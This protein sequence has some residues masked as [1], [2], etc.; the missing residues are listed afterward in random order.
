MMKITSLLIMLLTSFWSFSQNPI[1]DESYIDESFFDFKVRL[2]FAI[3]KKDK[4]LLKKLMYDKILEC[5]D[6]FDCAGY[7]GCDKN[8]FI[9]IYFKDSLSP[10]WKTLKNVVKFGFSRYKDTINYKHIKEPRDSLIFQAPSYSLKNG[11]VMIL[12]KDLN[13]REEPNNK[14]NILKT[15]SYQPYSCEL[16][17][18]GYVKIYDDSWIKLKFNV[19]TEGFVNQKYT[20]ESIDRNL[21]VAKI[22]GEWKIIEYFCKCEFKVKKQKNLC[23]TSTQL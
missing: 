23:L 13:V 6:S 2:E 9:D 4:E 8:D 16:S 12:A 15:I 11:E 10:H 19:G 5:W 1:N 20:S 14:S 17:D 3:I 22:N 21:K 18:D 7:E